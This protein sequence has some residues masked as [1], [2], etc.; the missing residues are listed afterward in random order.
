MACDRGE[1]ILRSVPQGGFFMQKSL[2]LEKG[3]KK[4]IW[5]I[6]TLWPYETIPNINGIAQ[7][8]SDIRG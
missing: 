4:F 6:L 5:Y 7:L 2:T 3:A 1:Y 8:F